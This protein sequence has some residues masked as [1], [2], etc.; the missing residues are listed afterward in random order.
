MD[1]GE[2]LEQIA[3]DIRPTS[4]VGDVGHKWCGRGLQICWDQVS[5][6]SEEIWCL[7]QN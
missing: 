7:K 3:F 4:Q 6:G 1:T 5:N 2:L